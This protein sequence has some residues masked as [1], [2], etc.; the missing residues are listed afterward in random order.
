MHRL[1]VNVGHSGLTTFDQEATKIFQQTTEADDF[2]CDISL[3]V[4]KEAVND[5]QF[6][7]IT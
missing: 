1:N 4:H 6:I 7:G 2:C 5:S 3:Q